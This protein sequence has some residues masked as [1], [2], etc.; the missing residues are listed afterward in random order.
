MPVPDQWFGY[1]PRHLKFPGPN[2]RFAVVSNSG[3]RVNVVDVDCDSPHFRNPDNT[4]K[5]GNVTLNPV[6]TTFETRDGLQNINLILPTF[7]CFGETADE[8]L[9]NTAMGVVFRFC[10]VSSN[11]DAAA[12]NDLM[13]NGVGT[14]MGIDV[15]RETGSY[16]VANF[17]SRVIYDCDLIL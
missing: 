14:L 17:D 2:F 9:V 5:K 10:V 1:E 3:S 16:L 6:F 13:A 7:I 8:V 12:R 4:P 11:C 15:I